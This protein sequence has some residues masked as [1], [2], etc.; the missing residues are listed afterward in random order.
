V[1]VAAPLTRELAETVD[2]TIAERPHAIVRDQVKAEV[3]KVVAEMRE[4]ESE[5]ARYRP[6]LPKMMVI[7]EQYEILSVERDGAEA[8][9]DKATAAVALVELDLE[10]CRVASP[11]SGRVRP[12]EADVGDLV[13]GSGSGKR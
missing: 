5:V 11:R 10:F 2:F 9:L 4:L 3:A 8:V 6:L 1:V 12:R 7:Q 13:L